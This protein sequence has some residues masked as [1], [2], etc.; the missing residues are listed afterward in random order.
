M[1]KKTASPSLAQPNLF[2]Q[3][4]ARAELAAG[5]SGKPETIWEMGDTATARD[6]ET[7][8]A[9]SEQLDAL[10]TRA[11][12]LKANLKATGDVFYFSH[13][14]QHGGP[15]SPTCRMVTK[16]GKSVAYVAQDRSNAYELKADQHA[17]LIEL[18]GEK[19]VRE[20]TELRTSYA[21]DGK[22]LAEK[23]RTGTVADVVA[24]A[25]TMIL[26]KQVKVGLL[27]QSQVDR[28]LVC[29]PALGFKPGLFD[30]LIQ[31]A[32]GSADSLARCYAAVGSAS[33]RFIKA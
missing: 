12:A 24:A 23:A 5:K 10:Q 28:L 27:S 15:P 31:F 18:L 6:I 22:V 3:A 33:V 13:T 25:L 11:D 4:A 19:P 1:P 29:K 20:M 17:S 8:L 30:R 16:A 9:I 26:E 7:F 14:A 32:R 2:D 21:F